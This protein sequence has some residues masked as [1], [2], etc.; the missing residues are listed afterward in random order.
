[1]AKSVKYQFKPIMLILLPEHK[2]SVAVAMNR[3]GTSRELFDIAF[4]IAEL[5]MMERK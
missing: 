3:H 4:K 2:V 1:M 5:F